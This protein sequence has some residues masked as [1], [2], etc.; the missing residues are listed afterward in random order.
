VLKLA[1]LAAADEGKDKDAG[2]ADGAVFDEDG[3][4]TAN[5]T[6]RKDVHAEARSM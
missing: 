1:P 6:C 2:E 5:G 3:R 4:T